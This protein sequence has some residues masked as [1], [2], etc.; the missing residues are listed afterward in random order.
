MVTRLSGGLTPGDGADPRTF[1]AIWNATA[2]DIEAAESDIDALE[3]KNIPAF[4][5]ATPSDGQVLAYSTA[6]SAYEPSGGVDDLSSLS[7]VSITSVSDGELLAYD[8]GTSEW[9][10]QALESAQL[11]AG[12]VLQAVSTTKTDAF[13]TSS[14]SFVDVTGL[15]ATITPSSTSSKILILFSAM[16]ANNTTNRNYLVNFVRNS[17]NIAQSTGGS[18][19]NQTFTSFVADANRVMTETA[20]FLDSPNTTSSTTYKIQIANA[21]GGTSFVNQSVSG[22][23]GGISTITLLEVAG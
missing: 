6:I 2:T 16:M 21:V 1:P 9:I 18:S 19:R 7:D 13:S 3:A 14:T 15:S 11:P 5:T 10:N 17:T 8:S 22:N 23:D 20:H 4:G 12:S